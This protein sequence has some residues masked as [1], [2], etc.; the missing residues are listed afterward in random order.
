VARLLGGTGAERNA[1]VKSRT[2][3]T[4][5]YGQGEA[6]TLRGRNLEYRSDSADQLRWCYY[7]GVRRSTMQE[8]AGEGFM[9][10]LRK[11]I[12]LQTYFATLPKKNGKGEEI[13][14]H[15]IG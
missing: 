15:L 5:R 1:K 6:D 10:G 8:G 7:S 12:G 13:T 4:K 11:T 2:T 3:I 14:S 9:W